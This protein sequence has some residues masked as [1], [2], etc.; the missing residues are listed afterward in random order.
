[1]PASCRKGIR[2]VYHTAGPTIVA[3]DRLAGRK[4]S[5]P[6]LAPGTVR[7]IKAILGE[8]LPVVLKNPI[9]TGGLGT[10]PGTY[11]LLVDA[12]LADPNFDLLVTF[13]CPHKNW[14]NPTR[15]LI[16]AHQKSHKPVLTCYISTVKGVEEDREALQQAGIPLCHRMKQPGCC[17]ADS[18][19]PEVPFMETRR[20]INVRK[21][22]RTF[23]TRWNQGPCCRNTR[24]P[25]G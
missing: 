6:G 10:R 19:Q 7:R 25:A 23:L 9:D 22:G 8:N 4:I 16:A 5:I 12:A 20:I 15:E 24:Y 14:P 1:M 17:R 13:C 3:L 11:G 2:P 18:L 21:S